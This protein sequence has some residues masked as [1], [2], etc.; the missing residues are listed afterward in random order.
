MM[1]G[2]E[3]SQAKDS[4]MNKLEQAHGRMATHIQGLPKQTANCVC[5]VPLG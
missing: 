3:I 2:L 5:I 4:D 1:Y